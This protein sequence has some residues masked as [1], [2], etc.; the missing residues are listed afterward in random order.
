MEIAGTLARLGN[1]ILSMIAAIMILLMLLYGGYSLWDTVMVYRG[2]FLS[3]DLLQ[4]KPAED[5]VESPTLLELQAINPDVQGWLTIDDTHIDY[6]V[7]QGENDM[8]YVNKDVYG[9]FALSGAI[10]LSSLDNLEFDE[11]YLCCMGIIWITAECSGISW[12]F[13]RNLI[14]TAIHPVC[15]I[16]RMQPMILHCL[17]A[18]R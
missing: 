18:W 2:A 6:P 7:V 4:F 8:E 15:F 14:L 9:E 11:G 13:R 1:R 17:H 5:A 3:S 10:F 16:C 12:N